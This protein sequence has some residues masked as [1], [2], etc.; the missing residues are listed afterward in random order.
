VLRPTRRGFRMWCSRVLEALRKVYMQVPSVVAAIIPF[1]SIHISCSFQAYPRTPSTW[2]TRQTT[3]RPTTKCTI[4][5]RH[6]RRISAMVVSNYRA[7]IT[8]VLTMYQTMATTTSEVMSTARQHFEESVQLAASQSHPS[9]SRR[10][11][12]L[13]K[14]RLLVN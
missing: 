7:H 13:L 5:V 2:Q 9:C 4:L 6:W 8:I 12:S 10:C 14:T 11:T 1:L 3:T